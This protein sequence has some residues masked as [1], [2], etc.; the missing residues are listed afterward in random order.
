MVWAGCTTALPRKI[1]GFSKL[2]SLKESSRLSWITISEGGGV[3]GG[4]VV[5]HNLGEK[6]RGGESG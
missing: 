5:S 2:E 3:D 4:S 1:L 6:G